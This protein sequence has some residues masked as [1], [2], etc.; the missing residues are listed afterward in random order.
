MYNTVWRVRR[1]YGIFSSPIRSFPICN[2]SPWVVSCCVGLLALLSILSIITWAFFT[3]II[4][5]EAVFCF[6]YS[7][8][9][10]RLKKTKST[11]APLILQNIT[12]R[13]GISILDT[14]HKNG[15]G[16]TQNMCSGKVTHL[17]KYMKGLTYRHLSPDVTSRSS[18]PPF[19][20]SDL[21]ATIY[22]LGDLENILNSVPF[23]FPIWAKPRSSPMG[24]L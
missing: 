11:A 19:L 14:S 17:V 1:H 24:L 9:T 23:H 22:L 16:E 18:G 7:L 5:W 8:S 4:L 2:F 10:Y 6:V 13:Y 12:Q 15:I 21:R 20:G 3:R